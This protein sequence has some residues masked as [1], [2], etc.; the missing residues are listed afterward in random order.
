[1][2]EQPEWLRAAWAE[3]GRLPHRRRRNRRGGNPRRTAGT[4][5]LVPGCEVHPCRR[6]VGHFPAPG[7]SPP[8][9]HGRRRGLGGCYALWGGVVSLGA[10]RGLPVAD[11]WPSPAL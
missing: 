1:L 2:P 7:D 4:R 5:G 11:R 9:G 3:G 10:R 6:G 8:G